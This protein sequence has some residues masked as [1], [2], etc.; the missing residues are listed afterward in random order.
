MKEPIS[1]QCRFLQKET[2]PLAGAG[3]SFDPFADRFKIGE[4]TWSASG[5]GR[6]VEDA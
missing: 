6:G 3:F 2:L 4:M 1:R 5:E